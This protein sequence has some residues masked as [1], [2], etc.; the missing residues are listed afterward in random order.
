MCSTPAPPLTARVAASIWSGV[1]DV[2][3]CPGQAAS[4]IPL[5]TKPRV[6]GFVAAA[7]A[8]NDADLALDRRVR[9]HHVGR[10]EADLENI[11][12]RQGQAVQGFAHHVPRIVDQFFHV[13][14]KVS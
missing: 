14:S 7:A 8:R 10:I 12:M 9:P 6:H 4:S 13:V 1:G 5:P 2:K 3:T 11:R